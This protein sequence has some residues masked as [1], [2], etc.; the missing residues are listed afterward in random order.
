[1]Y[2][3]TSLFLEEL[4]NEVL[5]LD[6]KGDI[7]PRIEKDLETVYGEDLRVVAS[8]HYYHA[9][10]II[11]FMIYYSGRA[12]GDY[13]LDTTVDIIDHHLQDKLQEEIAWEDH[14]YDLLRKMELDGSYLEPN[15]CYSDFYSDLHKDLY[16]FRPR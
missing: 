8:V 5:D 4:Y 16:G 12:F 6:R 7:Y 11:R 1:M 3:S 14:A 9:A 15:G 13:D 10:P 2:Q